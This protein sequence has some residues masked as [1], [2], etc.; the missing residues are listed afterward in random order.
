MLNRPDSLNPAVTRLSA[1]AFHFCTLT[2]PAVISLSICAV[3][4]L[5][6][7]LLCFCCKHQLL[8]V[9]LTTVGLVVTYSVCM[10]ALILYFDLTVAWATTEAE[11]ESVVAG[12]GA[13]LVFTGLFFGPAASVLL[14]IAGFAVNYSR[15]MLILS[16][17]C[18][19][20]P[21]V[22][23]FLGRPTHSPRSDNPYCPPDT[24]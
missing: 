6:Y 2:T 4:V 12:D 3:W 14:A 9:A 18:R 16:R 10:G 13:K 5:V 8:F 23:G 15:R 21:D 19:S 17:P 11:I 20:H 1:P 24:V 22:D 7:L